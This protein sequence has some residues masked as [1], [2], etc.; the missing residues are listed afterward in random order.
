[1]SSLKQKPLHPPHTKMKVQQLTVVIKGNTTKELSQ[2]GG[3]LIL[4]ILSFPFLF[5]LFFLLADTPGE[6]LQIRDLL[7]VIADGTEVKMN[8]RHIRLNRM[9]FSNLNMLMKT[10]KL[11]NQPPRFRL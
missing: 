8:A 2:A 9:G 10:G 11:I 4:L 7:L 5:I 1:M 6:A 3:R